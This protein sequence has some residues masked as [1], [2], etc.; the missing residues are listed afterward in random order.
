[1]DLF[2]FFPV[3]TVDLDQLNYV[4]SFFVVMFKEQKNLF[5]KIGCGGKTLR[6]WQQW[7]SFFSFRHNALRSPPLSFPFSIKKR[8]HLQSVS[9]T[10]VLWNFSLLYV[11]FLLIYFIIILLWFFHSANDMCWWEAFHFAI[12]YLVWFIQNSWINFFAFRFFRVLFF[13]I[14]V[15]VSI[16]LFICLFLLILV[17]YSLASFSVR[18]VFSFLP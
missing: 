5:N 11:I 2:L 15:L 3:H 14:S 9:V 13:S 7:N 17:F 16:S 12:S 6:L 18:F 8:K 4:V 10:A 1:M